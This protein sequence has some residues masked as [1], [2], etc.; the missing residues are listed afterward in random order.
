MRALLFVGVLMPLWSSYLIKAYTW[1]LMTGDAGPINWAL[2]KI[3]L[4]PL[5]IAFSTT[6]MWLAFTYIWL[7]YMVLPIYAALEIE[8]QGRIPRWSGRVLESRVVRALEKQGIS[9]ETL[10]RDGAR[11]ERELLRDEIPAAARDAL[12]S[13]RGAI[14]GTYPDLVSAATSVDPTLQK[15]VESSRNAALAG[16]ADIEKRLISHLK[17]KNEIVTS[18]LSRARTSLFPNGEPQERVISAISW[19]GRFGPTFVEEAAAAVQSGAAS[20]EP[21]QHRS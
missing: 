4:G 17:K 15:P 3:D 8:R 18:Q 16:L 2:A 20:L 12:R 6:A 13:L 11:L 5:H 19:L 21:A 9:A 10:E 14:E 1:R 7:P